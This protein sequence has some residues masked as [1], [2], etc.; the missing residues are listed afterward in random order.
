MQGLVKDME[1]PFG[2]PGDVSEM[3]LLLVTVF[4]QQL[5]VIAIL[6]MLLELAAMDKK[7][8]VGFPSCHS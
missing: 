4:I 3:N 7:W 2:I 6:V 8:K 5:P 1:L